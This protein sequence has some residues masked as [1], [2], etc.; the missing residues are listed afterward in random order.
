MLSS[1]RTAAPATAS[2]SAARCAI[3]WVNQVRRRSSGLRKA[4][5]WCFEQL[6][7]VPRQDV[8]RIRLVYSAEGRQ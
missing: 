6:T 4:R 3:N 1:C 2:V 5:S 8:W 7:D